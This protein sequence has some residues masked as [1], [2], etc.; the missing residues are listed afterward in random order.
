MKTVRII[1]IIL[2]LAGIGL[3]FV[4]NYVADEVAHGRKRISNAQKSVDRSRSITDLSPVTKDAGDMFADGAQKKI[5]EGKGEANEYQV[6]ADW[7]HGGGIAVFV[8]GAGLLIFSF[9]GKKRR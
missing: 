2:L 7:L 5:D 9:F 3:Y 4:G 8:I 1:G 6:M